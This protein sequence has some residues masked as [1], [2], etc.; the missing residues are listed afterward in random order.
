MRFAIACM[1]GIAGGNVAFQILALRTLE[2]EKRELTWMEV[3][4]KVLGAFHL[5]HTQPSSQSCQT[6]VVHIM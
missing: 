1:G 5:D 3:P 6:T 2:L 4:G